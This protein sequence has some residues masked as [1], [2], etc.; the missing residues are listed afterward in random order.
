MK[1]VLYTFFTVLLLVFSASSLKAQETVGCGL[2]KKLTELYALYPGLEADQQALLERSKHYS[3]TRSGD[4]EEVYTIPVVFHIIHLNGSENISDAQIIDQMAILNRD[5]RKLNADTSEIMDEFTDLAADTKIEFRLA[6]IDPFGN[7]TNGIEHIYSHE[8][9]NGDDYSKLNQWPR[10]RYLNVWIVRSMEDGVAGY[11]YYPSAVSTGLHF[12]DGIIILNNFVG[13]IGTSNDYS[14][15]ALTHEIGHWLGLPHVWGSTNS[16]GV[17][18]GD[19]GVEDTPETAGHETCIL[20]DTDDCHDGVPENVQN[21]MEYSYCSR[22]FTLGQQDVM[23]LTLETPISGRNNL[24]TEA[25][26]TN[27]GIVGAAV[28]CTPLPDFYSNKDVIC[29]GGTIQYFASISRAPVEAYSWSFPGGSPSTSNSASPI[30]TYDTPGIYPVELT[31]TNAAGSETMIKT[32]YAHI[33]GDFWKYEGP[34]SENF[35][36][37]NFNTDGWYVFNPENNDVKWELIDHAGRSGSQCIGLDYFIADPDPILEPH[38]YERQGGTKDIVITPSYNLDN[39]SGAVLSFKYIYATTSGG[40]FDKEDL[41]LKIYYRKNCSDVW[42]TL[43]ILNPSDLIS[44]GY[45]ADAFYP[46]SGDNWQSYSVSLPGGAYA[47]NVRFKLEFTATDYLNNFFIDDFNISGVLSTDGDDLTL[48]GVE[49]YPNPTQNGSGTTLSFYSPTN[50][51]VDLTVYDV[52]GNLVYSET[53]QT[54][55]GINTH[56]F[57]LDGSTLSR[58]IYNVVLTTEQ[59]RITKRLTLN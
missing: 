42:N 52:L 57:L 1:H 45:H 48:Q 58:G 3:T 43:D 7:C 4:R 54:Q 13:S 55:L 31:V 56:S 51:S 19:D 36:N 27:S 35:E 32:S 15:R 33:L 53:I 30:V 28:L 34:Y 2:Q 49:L 46:T 22:M 21:Y 5:F 59:S 44:A 38:Y 11:A 24:H 39:T 41:G 26:R 18:C 17:A 9:N 8:T 12:A 10:T 37:N 6:N 14:S 40:L 25:N 29:P 50:E 16:P 23:S 20:I 47:T